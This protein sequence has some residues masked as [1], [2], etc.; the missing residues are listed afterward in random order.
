M[1]EDVKEFIDE[2]YEKAEKELNKEEEE[3]AEP[4][5]QPKS[6]FDVLMEAAEDYDE[7]KVRKTFAKIKKS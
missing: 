6:Y 2:V 4:L 3:K 1:E 7:D 5:P